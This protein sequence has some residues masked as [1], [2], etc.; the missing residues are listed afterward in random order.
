MSQR[1]VLAAVQNNQLVELANL[2]HAHPSVNINWKNELGST[3]LLQAC[4]FGHHSI[5]AT[6]LAHPHIDVNFPN[7]LGQSPLL[8]ACKR[9]GTQVVL[10]LLNDPRV[11]VNLADSSSQACSPLWFVA[12]TNRIG[13]LRWILALRGTQLDLA[14]R[15]KKT[16]ALQIAVENGFTKT[17]SLLRD[18]AAT[19]YQVMQR[20]QTQ[21]G[22]CPSAVAHNIFAMI[23][24]LCE[25]LLAISVSSSSSSPKSAAR[26]FFAI[27]VQLPIELQM[28][29]C[30]RVQGS[31]RDIILSTKS[32]IAFR[33]LVERLNN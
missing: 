23:V 29:L 18:F 2:V 17:A 10:Q 26:R 12:A 3:P 25:N 11:D 7:I 14:R 13:L 6:L 22:V 21:L 30:H 15:C 9:S 1:K 20:L 8:I 28:S 24:F 4:Y 32:E 5:V 31:S 33:V 16:T 19:P 27:A